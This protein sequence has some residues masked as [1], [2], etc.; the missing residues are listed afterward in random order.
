MT[1][2]RYTRTGK[3]IF[4]GGKHMADAADELAA[5]QILNALRDIEYR[6]KR[7]VTAPLTL[8]NCRVR[9][10]NDEMACDCGL[11][12]AVDDPEPPLCI[13]RAPR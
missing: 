4:D 9:Q 3:Q 5:M 6:A 10:E 12:W 2:S 8:N 11:R 1:T 13:H 7:K